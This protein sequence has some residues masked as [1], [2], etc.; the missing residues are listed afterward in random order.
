MCQQ[1][2]HTSLQIL[3]QKGHNPNLHIDEIRHLLLETTNPTM[4]VADRILEAIH[5]TGTDPD[6]TIGTANL[7]SHPIIPTP[8]QTQDLLRLRALTE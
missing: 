5:K 6:P 4:I 8:G 2:S 1:G 3:I 7:Q